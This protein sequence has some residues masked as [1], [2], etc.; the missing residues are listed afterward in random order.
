MTGIALILNFFKICLVSEL[1]SQGLDSF[2]K[3]ERLIRRR[4]RNIL[5]QVD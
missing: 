5:M 3:I 2:K 1:V 4:M